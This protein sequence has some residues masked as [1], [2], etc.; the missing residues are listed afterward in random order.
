MSI[1]CC[2]C[3]LSFKRLPA[4]VVLALISLTAWADEKPIAPVSQIIETYQVTKEMTELVSAQRKAIKTDEDLRGFYDAITLAHE[5]I[6]PF[7]VLIAETDAPKE[8]QTYAISVAIAAKALDLAV[9]NYVNALLVDKQVYLDNA[10]SL[11]R[12]SVEELERAL[13]IAPEKD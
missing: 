5:K 2:I 10:D 7:I 8:V 12:Q 1:K 6:E 11:L 9:W 13:Q 3:G 4:I